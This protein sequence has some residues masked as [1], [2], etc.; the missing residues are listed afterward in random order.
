M[1]LGT[2]ACIAESF[3]EMWHTLD[4]WLLCCSQLLLRVPL[5]PFSALADYLDPQEHT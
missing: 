5:L 1:L 3:R 2:Q 4:I